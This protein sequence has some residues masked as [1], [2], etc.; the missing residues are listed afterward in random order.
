MFV[1]IIRRLLQTIPVLIGVS[2]IVFSL[3]HLVPGDPAI[4]I[5][6]ESAP[7][8]TVENIRERLGLND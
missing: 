4:M 8:Q 5:A 6:G 2:I 3:L 7:Q 1:F